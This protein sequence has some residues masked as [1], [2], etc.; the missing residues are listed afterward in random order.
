MMEKIKEYFIITIGFIITS[1]GIQYFYVPSNI[2]G[3]GLTGISIV[4]NHYLPSL[5]IGMIMMAINVVLFV[6]G[7]IVIGGNFGAKTIYAS[8]GVSGT[9]WF[10]EKVLNPQRL[11][12]DILLSVI[13]GTLLIGTGIGIVFTQN[14]STGGTDI[15]AKILNKYFNIELG[16]AIQ[17]IDIFILI[18]VAFTFGISKSLYAFICVILNGIV[19]DKIIEGFSSVKAVMVYSNDCEIIRDYIINEINRGCTLFYAEGGYKNEKRKVVY[20]VMDRTQLVKLRTF[21]KKNYPNAFIIVNTAHEVL[22]QG[23]QNIR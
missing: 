10:I 11:T 4:I 23:F 20:S 8:F 19:I 6:I 18:L 17:L 9:L 7:F 16:K 2:T 5:P 22:G 3:G 12:N 1:I 14:A 15:I 21:I 13:I